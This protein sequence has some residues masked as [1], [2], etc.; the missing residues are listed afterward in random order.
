MFTVTGECK[1]LPVALKRFHRKTVK[2]P[3]ATYLLSLIVKSE[4]FP[5][6]PPQEIPQRIE[7]TLEKKAV[8][9]ICDK[10]NTLSINM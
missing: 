5:S 6:D 2:L 8:R 4:E 1:I 3:S 9:L 7:Q 10:V